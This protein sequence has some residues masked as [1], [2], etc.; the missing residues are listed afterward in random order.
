MHQ[1]CIDYNKD[2]LTQRSCYAEERHRKTKTDVT[3]KEQ[4]PDVAAGAARRARRTDEA[5]TKEREVTQQSHPN[6]ESNL[7]PNH[8]AFIASSA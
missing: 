5:K 8:H 1:G 6:A 7:K 3:T 4:A 2:K